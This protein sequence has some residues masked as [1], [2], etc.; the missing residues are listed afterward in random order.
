MT[1]WSSAS[2]ALVLSSGG[3]E[4]AYAVGVMKALLSRKSAI[5][6]LPLDPEVFKAPRSAPSTPPSGGAAGRDGLCFGL[7]TQGAGLARRF[8]E[9][10]PGTGALRIRANPFEFLD[11]SRFITNPLQW[12]LNL[13]EDSA[14]FAREG[15]RTPV[16][17]LCA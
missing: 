4:G 5:D 10:P 8:G 2:Q 17:K 1:T 3:A 6:Q 16:P 9:H 13:A 12:F 15:S 14:Y 11:P 7:G